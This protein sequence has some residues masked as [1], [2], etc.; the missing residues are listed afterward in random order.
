MR[1]I[2]I[3]DHFKSKSSWVDWSNT[4]D[5]FKTGDPQRQVNT[6]AVAWKAN[7]DAMKEAVERGAE[8]FVSH[9]SICVKAVNGSAEQEKVFAL[10]SEAPK[11]QWL[12]ETGLTVYRCHD[13]WDRFPSIGIRHSWQRGL[14]IGD[15]IVGDE[16][17]LL[18][19]EI[20]GR[21]LGDLAR[22]VLERIE[23]LG[24]NGVAVVGDLKTPV[25]K[26]ATGTGVTT[27]PVEMMRLGA[28]SGIITDDYFLNVRM[29]EHAREL[30]FSWIVVNHGVSEFWGI[31]NL[32]EYLK[33]TFPELNVI[34]IPQ[35]CPYTIVV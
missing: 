29:G 10:P 22:H 15:R 9:E 26:I 25:T 5:T 27:N 21:T 8:M 19:T 28:D 23:P 30:G 3:H 7:W 4:T 17:P 12:E 13:C 14:E 33:T 35:R 1:C 16:Y 20:E 6:L 32:A 31:E 34:H 11:F 18:V 24:Q 2:D